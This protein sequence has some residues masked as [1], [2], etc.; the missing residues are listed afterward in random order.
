MRKTSTSSRAGFARSPHEGRG[1]KAEGTGLERT[2]AVSIASKRRKVAISVVYREGH[3]RVIASRA[4]AAGARVLAIAGRKRPT[5]NRW[6]LQI[7]RDVHI[8]A[9]PD[10]AFEQQVERFPWRFLNH[11]CEP[12]TKIDGLNVIRARADRCRRDELTVQLQLDRARYGI[13]R[14]PATARVR[15]VRGRS[16]AFGI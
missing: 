3:Y 1:H 9:D 11:G 12:N 8:E 15:S 4:F 6:T 10:V 5:P 16:A 13:V 7:D 2:N 14:L